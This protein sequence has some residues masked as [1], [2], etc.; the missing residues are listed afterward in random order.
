MRIGIEAQRLF[1]ERKHGM[2]VVALETIRELQKLTHSHE[3]VVFVKEDNHVCITSND[4]MEV[5]Q[6]PSSPYPVWEQLS[7]R[8]ALNKHK[9]D[10]IHCT[11]NTAP[12]FLKKNLIL[13]LH[14]IIY[15]ESVSFSGS[16]YQNFGNLYRRF[17]VPKIVDQCSFI[18]TVSNYEITGHVCQGYQQQIPLFRLWLV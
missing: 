6:L 11:A 13:T 18:I 5:V 14:D 12:L 2:E 10:L 9:V 17:I 4:T 16:A 7:L 1:R 8:K 3:I 15:L